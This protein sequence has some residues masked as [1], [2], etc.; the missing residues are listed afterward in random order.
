METAFGKEKTIGI[1][2]EA[3]T[4]LASRTVFLEERKTLLAA[5]LHLGRAQAFRVNGFYL[6]EGSDESDLRLLERVVGAKG[7]KRLVILGDLFHMDDGLTE[8]T[9][10]RFGQWLEVLGIEVV[11]VEGNHDRRLARRLGSFS[12]KISCVPVE[13]N[14]FVYAHEPEKRA[15]RFVFCGHLHPG[16]RVV[17]AA[18]CR[19]REK[20]F[21][22]FPD[23]LVLPAFG[24]ST[25]MGAAR[26]ERGERQFVCSDEGVFEWP[27]P[28]VARNA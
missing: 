16:I 1:G 17:D 11:L 8:E 13:E 10:L 3:V 24:A 9:L 21:R 22:V 28:T 20:C 4:L 25:S 18:G 26:R 7:A 15:D 5:D 6:P 2:G 19:V 14:G 23:Q 27:L 12:M